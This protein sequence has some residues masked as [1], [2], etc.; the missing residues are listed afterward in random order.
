MKTQEKDDEN[1]QGEQVREESNILFS[2]CSYL[3]SQLVKAFFK[4]FGHD[5][6]SPTQTTTSDD[7]ND[8]PSETEKKINE[9]YVSTTSLTVSLA[10]RQ[11][12]RRSGPVRGGGGQNN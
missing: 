3:C 5:S 2:P 11:P 6:P 9:E 1:E 4:C 10:R 12:P 8:V 7:P